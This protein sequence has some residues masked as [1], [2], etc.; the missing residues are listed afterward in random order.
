MKKQC[1]L[2]QFYNVSNTK[3]SV[4][5]QTPLK[6]SV[7]K[8]ENLL[9]SG[10]STKLS[11]KNIKDE[12][13]CNFNSEEKKEKEEKTQ[14]NLNDIKVEPPIITKNE[15]DDDEEIILTKRNLRKPKLMES[16]SDYSEGENKNGSA[17]KENKITDAPKKE[18]GRKKTNPTSAKTNHT[19]ASNSSAVDFDF[20]NPIKEA[21]E[22]NIVMDDFEDKIP[23]W[24]TPEQCKDKNGKKP[25]D[26]DYD[27]STL[28]VPPE[29]KKKLTP[30]M[31]QYWEIKSD[32]FDK[33][34]FFKLGKLSNNVMIIVK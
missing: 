13:D 8:E 1:S 25:T 21:N 6:S 29:E 30:T 22:K 4:S 20:F 9:N 31:K 17:D 26:P 28:Y 2:F 10:I 23:L 3:S 16:D 24:A 15:E 18:N 34:I 5:G 12:F 19:R 27:P 14:E 7:K 33:V 11:K 32:N